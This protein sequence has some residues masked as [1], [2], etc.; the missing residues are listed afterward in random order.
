MTQKEMFP[1]VTSSQLGIPANPSP[2]QESK[3][4]RKMT[5]TSGRTSLELLHT[6]DPLGAVSKMFMVTSL[7]DWTKCCLTWK[8]KA[9]P[10]GR[11]LFQLVP[12]VDPIEGIEF[13]VWPTPQAMDAMKARPVPAM[14]RQMDTARKGRTKIA[15]MKDSAVYGLNWH[16]EATRLGEGELNPQRLEWMMGYPIGWTEINASETL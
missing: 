13:T 15:T 3:E 4:A 2:S 10:Q 1:T 6:K 14:K 8:A 9:T 11:L 16:G 7:W 5:A 12:Q